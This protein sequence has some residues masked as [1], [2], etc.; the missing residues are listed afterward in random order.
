MTT[1]KVL[2]T[3]SS[4]V[5]KTALCNRFICG[6][7]RE[8]R[9]S[10]VGVKVG[11]KELEIQGQKVA[12]LLWDIIGEPS[13]E[14]VPRTY[15][16]GASAVVYVFDLSRPGTRKNMEAD[17]AIIRRSLPGCL[18]RIV[19]N[20]KDLLSPEELQALAS[21]SRAALFTSAKTGDNVDGLFLG[22]GQELMGE[23]AGI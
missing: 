18:V 16:L 12:L 23:T 7:F 20:K 6:A 21:E 4:A 11:K 1:K 2:I 10:T 13:Q 9:E 5:G 19:G 14:K 22:I 15:F 3:G 8:G 17:L